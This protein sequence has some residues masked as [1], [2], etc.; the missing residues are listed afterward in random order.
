MKPSSPAEELPSV[1]PVPIGYLHTLYFDTKFKYLGADWEQVSIM[2]GAPNDWESENC[3]LIPYVKY[4]YTLVSKTNLQT[5]AAID[6]RIARGNKQV[7]RLAKL[8]KEKGPGSTLRIVRNT[9]VL[10]MQ[11]DSEEVAFNVE[12]HELID[13]HGNLLTDRIVLQR[14]SGDYPPHL[15]ELF[16]KGKV[17][18]SRRKG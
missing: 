9:I 5:R 6:A 10:K 4:V 11:P 3:Q 8:T 2:P 1:D 16:T 13:A 15:K 17:A 18:D 14:T 7:R 12:K